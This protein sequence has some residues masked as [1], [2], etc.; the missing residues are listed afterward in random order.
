MAAKRIEEA[1][2]ELLDGD[3]RKSALDFAAYLQANEILLGE[4]ENYWE[5]KF[6]DKCVCFIWVDGS[7]QL[8]GPW[9]VWSDQEPGTWISWS[10]EDSAHGS[11]DCSV[12]EP[13]KETA[14]KNANFCADCGGDCSPGKTKIILGK[15]FEHLCSSALAFTNPD[16]AALQCIKNMVDMRKSD[17]LKKTV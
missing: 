12:D 16:T 15:E 7:A 13:T 11:E 3:A 4:S 5:A 6:R 9:T 8:P 14:W 17:I 2:A 10:D 1:V